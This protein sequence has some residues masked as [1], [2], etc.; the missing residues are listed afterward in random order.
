MPE[1]TSGVLCLGSW[2]FALLAYGVAVDCSFK[3]EDCCNL[4]KVGEIMFEFVVAS[5]CVVCRFSVICA[6]CGILL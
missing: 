1:L 2:L 3:D 6:V 5:S 4:S